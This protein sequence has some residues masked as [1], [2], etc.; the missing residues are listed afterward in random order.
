MATIKQII[1]DR[2]GEP[3]E[4]VG[5]TTTFKNVLK[6]GKSI[7]IVKIY[8]GNQSGYEYSDLG[9]ELCK[10]CTEKLEKFLLNKAD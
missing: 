3:M 1:C 7:R 4:Y 6:R 10:E 8:N 2:C 9:Y 5:W